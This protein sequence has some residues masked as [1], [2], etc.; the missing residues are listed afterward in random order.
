MPLSEETEILDCRYS[1]VL[2]CDSYYDLLTNEGNTTI[3]HEEKPLLKGNLTR[4]S[5]VL[6]QGGGPLATSSL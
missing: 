4:K 6:C 3:E 2:I 1:N 5:T